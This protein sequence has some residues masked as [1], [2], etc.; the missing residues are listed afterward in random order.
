MTGQCPDHGRT[1]EGLRGVSLGRTA[2]CPKG[3]VLSAAFD[4]ARG[5][6]DVGDR[7]FEGV[8]TAAAVRPGAARTTDRFDG[9]R[10]VTDGAVDGSLGESF[11]DADQHGL[12]MKMIFNTHWVVKRLS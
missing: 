8:L 1:P 4:Q 10:A 3:G 2:S 9:R 5:R 11:A 7:V 12:I 6:D